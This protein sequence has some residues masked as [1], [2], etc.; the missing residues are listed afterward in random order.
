M[1]ICAIAAPCLAASATGRRESVFLFADI[2]ADMPPFLPRKRLAS[3]SP[4]SVTSSTPRKRVKLNDLLDAD[5][6]HSSDLQVV[7]N[8]TMGDD[9]DSAPSLSDI[10]SDEFEDEP[11]AA[12]TSQIQKEADQEEEYH[13]EDVNW[14]DAMADHATTPRKHDPIPGGVLELNLS[15]NMDEIDDYELA[16][17]A[18]TTKKGPTKIER[19]IRM[20]THRMH[21]QFLLYHNAI[22]NHWA[23][24]KE[25]QEI[26][27]KQLPPAITKEIQKWRAASGLESVQDGLSKDKTSRSKSAKKAKLT[28]GQDERSQRDWG[29]PST[30]LEHGKPDLSRGDPIVSLLKVLAAYW[31]KRFSITAPGLRK[32]GYASAAAR[33]RQIKSFKSDKHNPEKH[34]ERVENLHKFRQLAV[35]CEGS[36]DIGAQLFTALLRGIGIESRLVNNLQPSGFGWTKNEQADL[37][38]AGKN[39]EYTL[40]GSS[41]N[42][43]DA[44]GSPVSKER[45]AANNDTRRGRAREAQQAD[46]IDGKGLDSD[47]VGQDVWS[48]GDSVLSEIDDDSVIDVTPAAPARKPAKYDQDLPFPIY[49]T[50][51][52]SPINSRVIP[53]SPLVLPNPVAS[54]PEI[55]ST[56]E[57]RGAEAEKAKQ[58]MAYV[59]AHSS[60]GSAKDVTTRYLKKRMW[61]G[62]TKGSR[63]PIEKLPIYDTRGKIK[64]HEEHDWFKWLMSGYVR[65]DKM[66]TAVDDL[67]E[68]TELVPNHPDKTESKKEGD[69]LQSL[70]SSAEFVLER[71]L[72]RE[73]A[74]RTNAKPA[75][76]FATGK[77]DKQKDEN[78]YLRADVERC[79]SAES[80]H[81]EGR[82]IKEGEAPMKLVPIRAVTLTRKREVEEMQRQTGEKPTQGLYSR[83]QTEYIIPPPIKDGVIPR[84]A[85][86]NIDCFVPSMVPRGAV[87]IPIRGTVRICKKLNID[88]AEA[89]TGFEFGKKLAI[90]VVEGVV[91]AAENEQVV[92]DAWAEYSEQQRVKEEGKLE[93]AVLTLWKR[94]LMGLRIRERVSDTYQAVAEASGEVVDLGDGPGRL[95]DILSAAN[96]L[97]G[98]D[99]ASQDIGQDGGGFLLPHEDEQQAAS[100]C[101]LVVEHHDTVPEKKHKETMQYPTP[102]SMTSSHVNKSGRSRKSATEVSN[103][104]EPAEMNSD[105]DGLDAEDSEIEVKRTTLTKNGSKR[106][107]HVTVE[108]PKQKRPSTKEH[109]RAPDAAW[110]KEWARLPP[111]SSDRDDKEQVKAKQPSKAGKQKRTPGRPRKSSSSAQVATPRRKQQPRRASRKATFTSPYFDRDTGDESDD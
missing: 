4:S 51:V 111:T 21:V 61:P 9:D 109:S 34:G 105:S 24:D 64:R 59:V 39:T 1:Q 67:E 93:K 29:R 46:E 56:F 102:V 50:E 103:S 87:H 10:D 25:V 101:E 68:S 81:K 62:K 48:D 49:W 85:Y 98:Q 58:V 13:D 83:D 91:V 18:M 99:D 65:T 106:D 70:K 33:Q 107:P 14:E 73:E 5:P 108:I 76:T 72:R 55:L 38:K 97:S 7:K 110:P 52:I 12:N 100:S 92:R 15:R 63:I 28:I 78:V 60:D 74:L 11:H 96:D 66:R 8:F 44:G 41:R 6:G 77:G 84:N 90:P 82:Q 54:T 94:M 71:F 53:V 22:R 79:L 20:Q 37:K 86:G 32:Q 27:V 30:R 80:W 89:V 3:V 43:L 95:S 19:Q 16:R 31:K 23:C 45:S 40:K 104:L 47:I 42:S 69:T 75:R 88:Y 35:K 2:L 57:P 26:L 17:A 36:R